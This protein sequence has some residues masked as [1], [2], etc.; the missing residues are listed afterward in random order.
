MELEPKK[1]TKIYGE[2][3]LIV[4]LLIKKIEKFTNEIEVI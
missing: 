3:G 2:T 1:N 4:Y